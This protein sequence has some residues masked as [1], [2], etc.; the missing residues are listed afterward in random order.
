MLTF[1]LWSV[2][3]LIHG[4]VHA[5]AHAYTSV[6]RDK[7]ADRTQHIDFVLSH[8]S[9]LGSRMLS[10]IITGS[11]SLSLAAAAWE[12]AERTVGHSGGSACRR[13]RVCERS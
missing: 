4:C 7:N 13:K 11:L 8:T 5:C 9:H 1:I 10:Q 6:K 3:A 2:C 12:R